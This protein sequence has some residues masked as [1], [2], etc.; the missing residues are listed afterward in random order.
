[1]TDVTTLED[2]LERSVKL[3]S[4]YAA[5]LNAYD[6]GQRMTFRNADEWLAR[7]DVVNKLNKEQPWTQH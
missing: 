3:Q 2:A 1:M 6:G 7:L 5:L 4:H